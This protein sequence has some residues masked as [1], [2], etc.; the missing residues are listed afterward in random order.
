MM[1]FRPRI[2]FTLGILIFSTYAV[3]SARDWPLGT[4]VFPWIVGI[5]VMIL[6]VIQ[7]ALEISQS[8]SIAAPPKEDTGDLQ[9]DWSIGSRVVGAKAARFY[10]WLLGFLFCIWL[11]GFFVAVPLYTF[12][13]LK[14]SAKE[15]WLMTI[16]L[17]LATFIFFVLLFD[18]VLHLPWPTPVIAWPE[19]LIQG[20]IPQLDYWN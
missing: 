12:L 8:R 10:G 14:V 4:K 19:Q 16:S 5:P 18:Q 20:V 7:L 3:V 6:S 15:S 1:K 17:S 9:V 13:Y 2:L 11:L